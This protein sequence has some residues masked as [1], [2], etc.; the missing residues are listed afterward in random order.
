MT[1]EETLNWILGLMFVGLLFP[2]LV[3][4]IKLI[5][6]GGRRPRK[7]RELDHDLREDLSPIREEDSGMKGDQSGEVRHDKPDSDD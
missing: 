7:A 5:F 3:F 1:I 4:G 6:S 2:L